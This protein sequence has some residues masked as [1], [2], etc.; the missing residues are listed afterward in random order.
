MKAL[1]TGAH[2]TVGAALVR[3]L[4]ARGHAVAAW[5]R[6]IV[7]IDDY[8]A[9]EAFVRAEAPDVLYHLAIASRPTGRPNEAWLV[10][11]EWSSELS[12]IARVLGVKLVFASTVMVFSDQARGPFTRGSAP[13]AA[14]GYGY[15]KLR[16]EGRVRHQNPDAVI[17]RLG[18]QIGEAPGSNNMIDFLATRARELGRVPASTRWYPATSFLDDTVD[19][20]IGLAEMPPDVYML[21]ANERWTFYDIASALSRRH[22]GAW[23]VVPTDDF[24]FDQRMRDERV[25]MRS[26]KTRLPDLP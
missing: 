7:P 11:Y 14:E 8:H 10:H 12:W 21:D 6:Q 1:I 9:M 25:P 16:A 22:G 15:E 26:L 17:A 18:W 5:D 23:S 24:I 13:D 2:G 19:A 4:G 3:R 20:L